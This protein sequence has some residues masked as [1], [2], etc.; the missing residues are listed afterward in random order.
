[1]NSKVK[2]CIM[3][4]QF[5]GIVLQVECLC[6]PA[7]PPTCTSTNAISTCCTG[8]VVNTSANSGTISQGTEALYP[9]NMNCVWTIGPSSTISFQF[10]RLVAEYQYD[11]VTLRTCTDALC[12]SPVSTYVF[13]GGYSGMHEN[14]PSFVNAY[15]TTAGYIQI[16]FTSDGNKVYSG[17]LG[18]WTTACVVVNAICPIGFSGP[19]GGA[20]T[21]CVSGTYKNSS[22]SGTCIDCAQGTYSAAIGATSCMACPGNSSAPAGSSSFSACVCNIDYQGMV[23]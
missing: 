11:P 14:L 17:F 21:A 4:I 23:A 18:T 16:L 10:S 3:I 20:C 13:Y 12:T 22:G 1:M 6:A 2:K 8:G 7:A 19:N 9:T 15:T 5:L